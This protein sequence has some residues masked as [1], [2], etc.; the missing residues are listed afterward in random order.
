[1]SLASEA[2]DAPRTSAPL[3]KLA[4]LFRGPMVGRSAGTLGLARMFLLLS[5]LGAVIL[6]GLGAGVWRSQW[7]HTLRQAEAEARSSASVLA[8]HAEQSFM[9]ADFALEKVVRAVRGRAWEDVER[10]RALHNQLQRMRDEIGPIADFW[11]NDANGRLRLTSYAFP[12]PEGTGL[13]RDAFEAQVARDQGLF[14]GGPITGRVTAQRSFLLSRRIG[15][16]HTFQGVAIASANLE[17]LAEFWGELVLPPGT[18]ITLFR[19]D[20]GSV[21]ASWPEQLDTVPDAASLAAELD[22]E[23]VEGMS[24]LERNSDAWIGAYRRVGDWPIYLRVTQ[25]RGR[26]AAA[27]GERM[28]PL[29]QFWLLGAL[30]LA[31]TSVLAWRLAE[32]EESERRRLDAEV[33]ARTAELRNETQRLETLNRTGIALAANL[34]EDRAIQAAVGAATALTGALAGTFLHSAAPGDGGDEATRLPIHEP[35]SLFSSL[36]GMGSELIGAAVMSHGVVRSPDVTCDPRWS[37]GTATG[38]EAERE[39]GVRSCLIVPVIRR[40][41][42]LHG[43]LWLGHPEPD[44]FE[45]RHESL[46]HGI[47]AQAG[48]A[49]DNARLFRQAENEIEARRA[50]EDHQRVLVDELNHRV[51]NMLGTVRAVLSLSA[52]TAKDVDAFTETFTRRLSSLAETHILLS[53]GMHQSADLRR[54]ICKELDPYMA[55][56]STGMGTTRATL[57]GSDMTLPGTIA[58]PLGMAVHELATNAVKYGALSAPEGRIEVAWRTE[59]RGGETTLQ[60]EWRE[61]N[62]PPATEPTSAGFGTQLLQIVLVNQLS[63][64]C[65]FDY[66]DRGLTVQITLPLHG[67]MARTVSS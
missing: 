20:D 27:F 60:L 18:Q 11:L 49:L 53:E 43:T 59:Q 6:V 10:A 51:K 33:R 54:M 8:R 15:T 5:I 41:G 45:E 50:A 47:A 66:A 29:A 65:T 39:I 36:G 13:G 32:G 7:A 12:S 57:A 58:V 46:A 55:G 16:A 9:V 21:L 31:T 26:L 40:D 38:R 28:W 24:R 14:I 37:D 61:R 2:A 56:E 30:A 3:A 1:M 22:A 34:D 52:R 67:E 19:A 42:T 48:I 25:S 44:W 17:D 62:G 63:G 64:E 35:P 23:P 4:L